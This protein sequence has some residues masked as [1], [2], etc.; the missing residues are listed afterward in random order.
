MTS[1]TFI[2]MFFAMPSALDLVSDTRFRTLLSPAS[3]RSLPNSCRCGRTS[4]GK[5]DDIDDEAAPI[6]GADGSLDH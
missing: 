4:A 3:Y 5:T 1:Q 6:P 2:K